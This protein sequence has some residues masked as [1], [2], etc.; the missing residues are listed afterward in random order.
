MSSS[1]VQAALTLAYRPDETL[2]ESVINLAD[3]NKATLGLMPAGAIRALAERGD[4]LTAVDASGALAGYA[5]FSIAHGRV[6]LI[7]LCV[8][9]A[10][11]GKQVGQVLVRRLSEDHS[12]LAGIVLK[13]KR[14]YVEA[15]RLW[16]SLDFRPRS[17]VRGRGKDGAVLTVWW[18][19]NN[20]PDLFTLA[21]EPLT[22]TVA[23]D[24]NVFIDLAV[25]R[26]RAG[27][28]QSQPLEADWIRDQVTLKVTAESFREAAANP[29]AQMRVRQMTALAGFEAL[30]YPPSAHAKAKDEWERAVGVVP[31]KDRSDCS[32]IISAAA[33]GV[34]ILVTR[35]DRMIRTYAPAAASVFGMRVLHPL[36]LIVHLDELADAS[37][38]Q[39]AALR[40]TGFQVAV[41]GSGH[42]E[43]LDALLSNATGERRTAF[44]SLLRRIGADAAATRWWV[45]D[46]DGGTVAAWATISRDSESELEIPLLRSVPSTVGMTVAKL[47]AF[48]L[49]KDAVAQGLK[50]IRVSDP[51]LSVHTRVDLLTEGYREIDGQLEAAVLDV[52]NRSEAVESLSK[53]TLLG[54][55]VREAVQDATTPDRVVLLERALWPAKLLDSD[56]PSYLVAIQPVWARELF[57]LHDT[58][59]PEPSLLK[60]SREH[61]YYRTPGGSPRPPARIAWY[62]SGTGKRGIGAVVAVSHMVDV[63]TAPPV[64]LYNRYR[65]LGV[66]SR[67]NV[68]AA[69][70]DGV[71]TALRFVDTENLPH[72]V[73][74]DRLWTLPGAAKETTLQSPLEISGE[75]FGSIYDAGTRRL[76]G[77]MQRASGSGADSSGARTPVHNAQ[78]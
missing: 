15:T 9:P 26:E 20:I 27:A 4:V 1:G 7:H 28:E 65:R 62:A 2:T 45:R 36:D 14:D 67:E 5:M 77:P 29:D 40:G 34:K 69:E 75:F 24:H 57:A 78:T 50:R 25:Q 58:L 42:E 17:E 18:L 46:P 41:R 38:Y 73:A 6:R 64:Q 21:D 44:H 31:A 61:V 10:H 51:H 30:D 55:H 39:P 72:P 71:A 33:A 13:C 12:D 37:R 60:L 53:Q 23:I 52:R 76:A 68:A 74:F 70:R 47:I 16:K 35:D 32:H 59:W 56:L 19:S 3:Q 48:Q 54:R 66:Y 22:T 11:R 43:E 63:D 49:R 8:D